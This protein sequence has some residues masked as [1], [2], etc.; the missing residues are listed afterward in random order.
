MDA[1]DPTCWSVPRRLGNASVLSSVVPRYVN[2]TPW[3]EDQPYAPIVATVPSNERA[4]DE[5]KFPPVIVGVIFTGDPHVF[6]ERVYCQTAPFAV[7]SACP[8]MSMTVPPGAI[9]R[10][11]PNCGV[12]IYPVG[13]I[14]WE[15][16]QLSPEQS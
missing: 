8:A 16:V 7:L 5:P 1:A 13:V 4:T 6:P 10:N 9:V 12:P 15:R 3:A 11:A 2:A 14:V